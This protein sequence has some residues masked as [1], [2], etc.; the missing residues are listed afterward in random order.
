MKL[1]LDSN[2]S[3]IMSDNV[4][5]NVNGLDIESDPNKLLIEACEDSGIHI[6]RFCWHKRLRSSR[7]VQDVFS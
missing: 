7:N 5:I 1:N 3:S 4:K 6:P 2:K